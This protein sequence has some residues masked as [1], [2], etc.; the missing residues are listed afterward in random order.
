M[1]N[2]SAEYIPDLPKNIEIAEQFLSKILT[3]IAL[4]IRSSLN[5]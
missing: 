3:K 5:V 2:I 4:V 1:T